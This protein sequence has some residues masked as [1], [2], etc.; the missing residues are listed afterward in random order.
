MIL[1]ELHKLYLTWSVTVLF[2]CSSFRNAQYTTQAIF[3]QKTA[4]YKCIHY[5]DYKTQTIQKLTAE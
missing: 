1:R 2:I 4:A 3:T 5:A